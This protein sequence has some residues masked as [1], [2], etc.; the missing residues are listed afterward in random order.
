AR[1][2]CGTVHA[3]GATKP[4]RSTAGVD[5]HPRIDRSVCRIQPA[6]R[7]RAHQHARDGAGLSHL[8][9]SLPGTREQQRVEIGAPSLKPAPG[10]E[11]IAAE[12]FKA[13]RAAPLDP[14]SGMAGADHPS[15]PIR[16]P[17]LPEER[18][19]ARMERFA[20][21]VAA[22][23]FAL[24]HDDLHA[25]GGAGDRR[26]AARRAAADDDYVGIDWSTVHDPPSRLS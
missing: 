18:L 25:A 12:D 8:D 10:S 5:D 1:R 15:Q 24:A 2:P 6:R 19:N 7:P 9:S 26:G 23:S 13:T 21:T 11:R 4:S 20:R 14:D 22:G 16:D 3:E 17:Q